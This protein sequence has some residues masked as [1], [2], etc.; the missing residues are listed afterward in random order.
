DFDHEAFLG[1]SIEAIAAEKAG[2]LKPGIPA[3]L[4]SQRPEAAATLRARAA[5]VGC[6]VIESADWRVEDCVLDARGSRFTARRG[7]E[8]A[9]RAVCPLAGEHQVENALTAIAALHEMGVAREAIEAG[10]AATRWPGRLE[11]VSARPEIILDGA[12]N[13]SGARALV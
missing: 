6:P 2:I 3:V 8:F 4:G 9:V 1:R 10:I 11:P 5:A 13:P 7:R 12:H